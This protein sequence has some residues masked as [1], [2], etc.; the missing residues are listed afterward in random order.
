MAKLFRQQTA[1]FVDFKLRQLEAA[2]PE[3]NRQK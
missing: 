2:R 3:I 1:S